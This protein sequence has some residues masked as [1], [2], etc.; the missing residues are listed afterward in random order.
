[1]EW[2]PD[3]ERPG[4]SWPIELSRNEDDIHDAAEEYFE[5]VWWNRHQVAMEKIATGKMEPYEPK[6]LETAKA[7][8]KRIEDKYGR[9]NLG[10]SDF[11]CGMVIGKLSA[12]RW[13]QGAES[14]FLDT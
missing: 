8:A 11:E 9:C 3:E 10:W 13:V 14:D 5:E 7:A 6:I 12:I 4:D 2:I 1:M